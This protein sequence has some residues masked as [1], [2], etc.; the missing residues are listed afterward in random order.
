MRV[1]LSI[2]YGRKTSAWS[3]GQ[4]WGRASWGRCAFRKGGRLREPG[5]PT[6]DGAKGMPQGK[7]TTIEA[8]RT[9]RGRY[10]R[11]LRPAVALSVLALLAACGQAT[12]TTSP[13]KHVAATYGS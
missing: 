4:A 5:G 2:S 3:S 11:S 6:P 13:G 9:A 7:W 10:A 1:G 12:Q 8:G